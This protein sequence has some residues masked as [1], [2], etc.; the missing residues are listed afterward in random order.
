MA[1]FFQ[2]ESNADPS[3]GIRSDLSTY[4]GT[5]NFVLTSRMH[6]SSSRTF[7]IKNTNIVTFFRFFVSSYSIEFVFRMVEYFTKENKTQFVDENC[8]QHENT[9]GYITWGNCG[10]YRMKPP[11]SNDTVRHT[12]VIVG[13]ELR[14]YIHEERTI[15]GDLLNLCFQVEC[16]KPYRHHLRSVLNE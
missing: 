8:R 14:Q 9:D 7:D 6:S 13:I 15:N 10:M 11:R 5:H 4:E 3:L 1:G 2:P 12:V 16:W